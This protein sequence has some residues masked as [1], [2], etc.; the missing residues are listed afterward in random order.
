MHEGVTCDACSRADFRG[1][2]YKCLNCYDYDLCE[3]C[4]EEAV[5]SKSHKT[6]HAV[7]CILAPAD[8]ELYYAGEAA[9]QPQSFTCP[10]CAT[11]GFTLATLREHVLSEHAET[12]M[13]VV[14]P[15]CAATPGGDPNH[16]TRDFAVHLATAHARNRDPLDDQSAS[17]R[18]QRVSHYRF[19]E[20]ISPIPGRQ[21][22]RQLPPTA[23]VSP[24][25][26]PDL[27]Y[28][29][30]FSD[31][32]L[33]TLT[34]ERRTSTLSPP[35]WAAAEIQQMRLRFQAA[36]QELQ[37]ASRQP[38]RP[39]HRDLTPA[40]TFVDSLPPTRF[41]EQVAERPKPTLVEPPSPDDPRF[42]LNSIIDA[43]LSDSRQQALEVERADRSLFVQELLLSTL[44]QQAPLNPGGPWGDSKSPVAA[45]MGDTEPIV[46]TGRDPT[47]TTA[48]DPHAV[49]SSE[50][51]ATVGEE[52]AVTMSLEPINATSPAVT[53]SLEQYRQPAV[54]AS[55]ETTPPD[56]LELTAAG[57]L[58][59][60]STTSVEPT[61]PASLGAGALD[62]SGLTGHKPGVDSSQLPRA[63]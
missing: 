55:Q 11:T 40:V 37:T 45:A 12:K 14:C 61:A 36:R 34:G 22:Q 23:T 19:G 8:Y 13:H 59:P 21:P 18:P 38:N 56:S 20:I 42:L 52:S 29:S 32:L 6:D 57:D 50:K 26:G 27:E 3:T 43:G 35:N 60:A 51:T 39:R 63:K 10:V 48:L 1:K 30:T 24:V 4:Y 33:Q 28:G 53:I 41:P 46:S 47:A 44:T 25:L 2:R 49:T 15:V 5:T 62:S 16:M 54:V 17:R 58:G 9:D 7:Q 31:L